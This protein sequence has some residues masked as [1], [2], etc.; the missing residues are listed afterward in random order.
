L[1]WGETFVSIA[2]GLRLA[3]VSRT[4]LDSSWSEVL[5]DLEDKMAVFGQMLL[6]AGTRPSCHSD[7][8]TLNIPAGRAGHA[9]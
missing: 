3:M 1:Q 9:H 7:G 4:S 5:D 8:T 2:D 6:D